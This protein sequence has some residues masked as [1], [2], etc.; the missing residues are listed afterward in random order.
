MKLDIYQTI[1][2]RILFL[3]YRPGEIL[4]EKD[5]AA[6]FGVSKTPLR[7]ILSRLEF[8]KLVTVIPRAGIMVTQ[9]EF[10]KLTDVYQIRIYIEGLVVKLAAKKFSAV[11]VAEIKVIK[12]ACQKLLKKGDPE[13]LIKIDLRFR[14][15]LNRAA[16]NPI[17]MENSNYLYN[18]TLRVWFLVFKNIDWVAEVKL[19]INEIDKTLA[20]LVKGDAHRAEKIRQDFVAGYVEKIKNYF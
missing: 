7:E 8:E 16:G 6:E 4:K 1:R 11:H 10:Q 18:M 17:L 12:T 13:D 14:D 3:R 2:D 9:I 19:T 5:L 15:V 20:A